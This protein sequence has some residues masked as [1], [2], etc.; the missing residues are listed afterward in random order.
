[1][2]ISLSEAVSRASLINSV[3]IMLALSMLFSASLAFKYGVASLVAMSPQYVMKKWQQGS[4]V[5]TLESWQE[6]IDDMQLAARLNPGNSQYVFDLGELY[7]WRALDEPHWTGHA[8][9]FRSQAID[10]YRSATQL[11]PVW[12]LAWINLAKNKIINQQLDDE[13]MKA[14]EHAITFG[15][16]E[17]VVHR[18][19]IWLGLAVW[20]Y[21]PIKLQQKVSLVIERSFIENYDTKY[22]KVTAEHFEWQDNLKQIIKSQKSLIGNPS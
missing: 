14:L 10:Y 15:S 18:E 12:A 17:Y 7:E 20:D 3:I 13:A 16:W 21:L 6:A 8:R 22:I 9:D 2:K 1:M 11:R 5:K 19:I 4:Q